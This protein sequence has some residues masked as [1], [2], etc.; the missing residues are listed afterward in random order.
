MKMS[1]LLFINADG[2]LTEYGDIFKRGTEPK[3]SN[4]F[5]IFQEQAKKAQKEPSLMEKFVDKYS[6]FGDFEDA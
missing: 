4:T 5:F 2:Q 1:E 6:E 3:S